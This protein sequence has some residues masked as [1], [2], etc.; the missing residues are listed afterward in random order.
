[1]LLSWW[2]MVYRSFGVSLS[3]SLCCPSSAAVSCAICV[4]QAFQNRVCVMDCCILAYNHHHLRRPQTPGRPSHHYMTRS[5]LCAPLRK[6]RVIGISRWLIIKIC[7][8]IYAKQQQ[9][10]TRVCIRAIIMPALTWNVYFIRVIFFGLKFFAVYLHLP[11]ARFEYG[12]SPGWM[13]DD[14]EEMRGPIWC[15]S[16]FEL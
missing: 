9:H 2:K 1:M 16:L 3:L 12:N 15:G 5:G 8:P 6:Q 13:D 4:Y 10:Q 11:S 7:V 14:D